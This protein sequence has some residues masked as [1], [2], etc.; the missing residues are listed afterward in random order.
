MAS[1]WAQLLLP[2]ELAEALLKPILFDTEIYTHDVRSQMQ[3]HVH[4]AWNWVQQN[5][6]YI[7]TI[8]YGFWNDEI[9]T[10]IVFR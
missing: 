1:F 2:L 10:L 5:E 7:W 4:A 6:D 9:E 8:I 3:L